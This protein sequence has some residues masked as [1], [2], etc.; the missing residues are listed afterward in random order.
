MIPK[1]EKN[2]VDNPPKLDIRPINVLYFLIS[3]WPSLPRLK[4]NIL[5]T[6][7]IDLLSAL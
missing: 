2:E 6:S 5:I 7:G 3:L 4:L 1:P